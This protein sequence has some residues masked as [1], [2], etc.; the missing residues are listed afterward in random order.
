MSNVLPKSSHRKKPPPQV[1]GS[2]VRNTKKNLKKKM[3]A[4]VIVGWLQVLGLLCSALF[5]F[6][7]L[8]MCFGVV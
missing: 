4:I 8:V 6:I 7:T 5:C 1:T 2:S 3:L